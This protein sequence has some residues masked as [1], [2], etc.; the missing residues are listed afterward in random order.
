M[1][2]D[3]C[4]GCSSRITSSAAR[5]RTGRRFIY[6]LIFGPLRSEVAEDLEPLKAELLGWTEAAIRRL[7][8]AGLVTRDKVD[9]CSTA[10]RGLIVISTMDF[11]YGDRP[12]G[13]DLAVRQVDDIL[14][15]FGNGR[16]HAGLEGER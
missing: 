6:A 10:L 8:E 15:G 16:A 5:T 14:N 3:A 9:G 7:A 11:L 12:L 13:Q 4:S 2:C 1:R